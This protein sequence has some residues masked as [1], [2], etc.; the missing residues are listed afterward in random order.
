[1]TAEAGHRGRQRTRFLL[2]YALAVAGGSI[3]YAP[4]LTLLLP[5]RI[6]DLASDAG[7]SWIAYLTFAGAIC[8]SIANIAFGWASDLTGGRRGYIWAGLVLS[9]GL[10]VA[11][12]YATGFMQLLILI[13][14]WQI[15]LNMMLGPLFAW[16]GD[17]VPDR[18]KGLLGGLLSVA[19]A[20]GALS[21]AIVTF[22][23]FAAV[24]DGFGARLIAVALMVAGCVMPVL[25]F[26]RPKHIAALEPHAVRGARSAVPPQRKQIV[27]RMWLARL[28]V[29]I[30]EA[31]LFAYALLWFASID[32]SLDERGTAQVLSAVLIVAVPLALF[33]GRWIDR[34]DR[35]ILPLAVCAL[36]A[37][38]GLALMAL[39]Q[40]PAQA[41]ASYVLFG[42]PAAAFLSLHTSQ[43]LRVLPDPARRGRDM[44]VFNLT[45]SGPSLV[46]PWLVLTLVPLFGF[47]GLLALLA[48]LCG[49]A[50]LLLATAPR[51][52]PAPYAPVQ[53]AP[54]QA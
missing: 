27:V 40:S 24:L 13:C 31:A 7:V 48:M 30:C 45:N 14:C 50:A 11:M 8:A 34:R 9:G 47:S 6:M 2:L 43:T 15:A 3:A 16:A 35:P 32:P 18:Q 17:C 1:M 21:G 26:G 20:L 12:P 42:V 41:I 52:A 39:A 10:L 28:L 44:G 38:A 49:A 29:Q 36:V 33:T 19:P 23:G 22:S 46:M 54:E 51:V 25:L 53:V 37:A 5:G 4:L